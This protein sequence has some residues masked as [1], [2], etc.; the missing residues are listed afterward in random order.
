[1]NSH[2]WVK[3]GLILTLLRANKSGNVLTKIFFIFSRPITPI[4]QEH[5][6]PWRQVVLETKVCTATHIC[7]FLSVYLA[8]YQPSGA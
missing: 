1:M 6:N 5:T 8:L 7:G 4:Q 2:F 3:S